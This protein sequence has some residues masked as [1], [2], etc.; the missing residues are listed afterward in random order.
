MTRLILENSWLQLLELY[1]K[2][3]WLSKKRDELSFQS[4]AR[5]MKIVISFEIGT[6]PFFFKVRVRWIKKQEYQFLYGKE[7]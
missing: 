7:D 5:I 6:I 4:G 2:S 3:N 1:R